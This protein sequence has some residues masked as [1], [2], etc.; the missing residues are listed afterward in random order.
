MKHA[1]ANA[2]DATSRYSLSTK[3]LA[4]FLSI[5]MVVTFSH[6]NAFAEFIQGGAKDNSFVQVKTSLENVVITDTS[7]Q[8]SY[9]QADVDALGYL[10]AAADK[11]VTFTVTPYDNAATPDPDYTLSEVSYAGGALSPNA[12]GQYSFTPVEGAKLVVKAVAVAAETEKPAATDDAEGAATAE[13]SK[14]TEAPDSSRGAASTN[15]SN[16]AANA[17]AGTDSNKGAAEPTGAVDKTPAADNAAAGDATPATETPKADAA[18]TEK[19]AAP[20][21]PAGE[22][23]S[24]SDTPAASEP[25]PEPAVNT[26]SVNHIGGFFNLFGGINV[27]VKGSEGMLPADAVMSVSLVKDKAVEKMLDDLGVPAQNLM[28]DNF[29]G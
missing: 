29:G 2:E 26:F 25:A 4:V 10:P 14:G 5:A 1:I 8:V 13:D 19:P 6:F 18:A 22:A 11:V 7:T 28:F 12:S 20:A 21:Q 24:S 15:N 17:A 16:D 27:V 3:V 9:K 23:S